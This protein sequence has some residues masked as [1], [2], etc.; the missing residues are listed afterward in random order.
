LKYQIDT[1]KEDNILLKKEIEDWKTKFIGLESEWRMNHGNVEKLQNELKFSRLNHEREVA[2]RLSYERKLTMFIS[3]YRELESRFTVCA[4]EVHISS[5]T[6]RKNYKIMNDLK[7]ENVKMNEDMMQMYSENNQLKEIKN[8]LTQLNMNK[9]NL[10]EQIK[11]E[12]T[13]ASDNL[14]RIKETNNDL[15]FENKRMTTELGL[16]NDQHTS[17]KTERSTNILKIDSL[18]EILNKKDEVIQKINQELKDAKRNH[19]QTLKSTLIL[20]VDLNDMNRQFKNKCEDFNS[21]NVKFQDTLMN[22]NRTT[23]ELDSAK[24]NI[25][26]IS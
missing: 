25:N 12:L 15:V 1:L 11:S 9:E 20:E 17:Y 5:E 8:N 21:M 19:E 14:I 23:V 24:F 10:I 6:L 3:I 4:K 7:N 16:H 2:M 18:N 22:L 13:K 26:A